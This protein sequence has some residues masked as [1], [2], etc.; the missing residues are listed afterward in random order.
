MSWLSGRHPIMVRTLERIFQE[1]DRLDHTSPTSKGLALAR[2]KEQYMLA[3]KLVNLSH[4]DLGLR[5]L[6]QELQSAQDLR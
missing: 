4:Q 5:E 3:T 6:L 2:S 1:W